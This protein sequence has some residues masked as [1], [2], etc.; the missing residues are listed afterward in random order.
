MKK[1]SYSKKKKSITR[2]ILNEFN[3][4]KQA[5]ELGVSIWQT[6]NFLFV[7]MGIIIIAAMTGVYVISN[8]YNSIEVL[9][10][11]ES[12]VVMILFTIGNF[13]IKSVEEAAKSNKMKSEFISIASHQLKTPISEIK[14]EIELL[15]SKF[16]SGLT[17]K[18]DE[19]IKEISYSGKKMER[20]IND[21][22]DV[23]RIDQRNLVLSK[24]RLNM[25]KLIEEAIESQK[26]L[27]LSYNV[28]IKKVIKTKKP[29]IIGDKRRITVVLDNLISNAI[30]YS[31]EKG[32][33]EI[34]LEK[35]GGM[36]QVIV[37]DNGIGIPKSEQCNIFEKFFRSNN[38]SKNRTEGTGLGLYITKNIVEQ[39]GGSI[40]FD[41]IENVGSEFYFVLPSWNKNANH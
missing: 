21:L 33:V 30:K 9:V 35:K 5:D 20:L 36:I 31:E 13:I 38:S 4:K 6:P 40:W 34:I 22:L 7:V 24:D 18:Q 25:E 32:K 39:S 23:A 15:L 16:S 8:Y 3:L 14:W 11:S 28:E 19:I 37:R 41:S 2:R 12:M 26:E 10:L 27:A 1:L 29:D 17:K